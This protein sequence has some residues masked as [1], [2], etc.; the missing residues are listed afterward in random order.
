M[1]STSV[2]FHRAT[3]HT[4]GMP[5]RSLC[6]VF[7]TSLREEGHIVA[8]VMASAPAVFGAGVPESIFAITL[9]AFSRNVHLKQE[10]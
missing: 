4:S 1:A 5:V 7:A 9:L 3:L 8:G 6:P 10:P 2:A